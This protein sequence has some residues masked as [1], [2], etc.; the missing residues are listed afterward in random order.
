MITKDKANRLLNTPGHKISRKELKDLEEYGQWLEKTASEIEASQAPRMIA[1]DK[2]PVLEGNYMR[3]NRKAHHI[4]WKLASCNIPVKRIN[5]HWS[6][7]SNYGFTLEGLSHERPGTFIGKEILA[8][9]KLLA[10]DYAAVYGFIFR[11]RHKGMTTDELLI[12]FIQELCWCPP[13]D[14]RGEELYAYQELICPLGE[15]YKRPE[16]VRMPKNW[17]MDLLRAEESK[18]AGTKQ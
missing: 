4:E 16:L 12:T 9:K 2:S 7:I 5:S 8:Y 3:M 14:L 15:V 11:D 18:L 13:A 10:T 17:P 1:A 6:M